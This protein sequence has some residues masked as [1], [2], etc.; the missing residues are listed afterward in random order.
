MRQSLILPAFHKK[1]SLEVNGVYLYFSLASSLERHVEG[2]GSTFDAEHEDAQRDNDGNV[3]DCNVN[4]VYE[5]SDTEKGDTGD[6]KTK[7][8]ETI[9]TK[10]ETGAKEEGCDVKLNL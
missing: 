4:A 10:T 7:T 3:N 5:E 6:T 8:D 9:E 1:K 2:N